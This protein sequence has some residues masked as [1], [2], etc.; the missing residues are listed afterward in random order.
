MSEGD[1]LGLAW[2]RSIITMANALE[3]FNDAPSM[4][5][6]SYAGGLNAPG[7]TFWVSPR[8]VVAQAVTPDAAGPTLPANWTPYIETL[9]RSC[10]LDAFS[11]DARGAGSAGTADEG[12][13][14]VAGG[15]GSVTGLGS[16]AVWSCAQPNSA[17][18][19]TATPT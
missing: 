6:R 8:P 18:Q 11:P 3:L 4:D 14:N 10:L 7:T 9:P 2:G 12:S 16:G 15:R 1:V 19:P 13:G 17:A 5:R